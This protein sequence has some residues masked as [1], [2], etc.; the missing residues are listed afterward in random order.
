MVGIIF[1]IIYA[2]MIGVIL[3]LS[4]LADPELEGA[5]IAIACFWP[6][7]LIVGPFLLSVWLGNWITGKIIRK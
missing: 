4:K 5:F 1:I 7:L 6:L 2:L 3:R